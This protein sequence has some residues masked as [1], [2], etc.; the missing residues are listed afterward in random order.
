MVLVAAVLSVAAALGLMGL[1]VTFPQLLAC[2][3]L[4]SLGTMLVYPMQ[5]T[6]TARLAPEGLIGSYFGF[7]AISL[8]LGGAVVEVLQRL[9]QGDELARLRLAQCHFHLRPVQLTGFHRRG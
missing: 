6:L 2:V 1:A 4:Y 7:S 5:Q 8:G 3:A 9:V